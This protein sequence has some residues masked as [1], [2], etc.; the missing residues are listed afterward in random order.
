MMQWLVFHVDDGVLHRCRT[1]RD[2]RQAAQAHYLEQ[3]RPRRL[4]AGLYALPRHLIGRQAELRQEG[5][6]EGRL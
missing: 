6:E 3:I 1:Y 2:A 4:R 5:I